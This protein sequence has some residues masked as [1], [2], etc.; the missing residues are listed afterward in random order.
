MGPR[1]LP[2]SLRGLRFF[3]GCPRALALDVV[4]DGSEDAGVVRL[5]DA[6]EADAAEMAEG[7]VIAGETPGTRGAVSGAAGDT[8]ANCDSKFCVSRAR[9]AAAAAMGQ[10]G[11]LEVGVGVGVGA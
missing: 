6:C 4:P 5:L 7:E 2:L 11:R 1:F 3:L 9:T 8:L 10:L